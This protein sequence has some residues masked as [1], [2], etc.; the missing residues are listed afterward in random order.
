MKPTQKQIGAYLT[1]ISL[2]GQMIKSVP[3]GIPAGHLYSSV[4]S[5]M[6]LDTFESMIGKMVD[7][8]LITRA[9][10]HLL[11]WAGPK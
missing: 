3:N 6:A 1:V 5:M 10:S 9:P 11:T 4:M 2:L 8:G 7:A